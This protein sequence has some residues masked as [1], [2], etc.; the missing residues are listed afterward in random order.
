M[1]VFPTVRDI[2]PRCEQGSIV[3]VV[4]KATGEM[5]LVCQECDATWLNESE[6]SL[7]A[8]EDFETILESKGL[9]PLWSELAPPT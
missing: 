1:Q 6:I 4:L 5:L 7:L 9:P 3:H 8:F 2:C